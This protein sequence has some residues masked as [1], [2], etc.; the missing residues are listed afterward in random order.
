MSLVDA[1]WVGPYG[2]RLPDGTLLETGVTVVAVGKDEAEAS[3][4]W[5][6]KGRA[7]KDTRLAIPIH[8]PPKDED[9][10]PVQEPAQSVAGDDGGKS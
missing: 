3:E 1:L 8:V 10:E 5:K 7:G 2:H 6:V 9:D 4:N